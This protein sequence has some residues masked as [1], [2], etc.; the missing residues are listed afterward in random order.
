MLRR[1]RTVRVYAPIGTAAAPI[2][3]F[4]GFAARSCNDA[5][6]AGFDDGV[7]NT[8]RLVQNTRYGAMRCMETSWSPYVVLA[9]AN[10]SAGPPCRISAAS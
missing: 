7:T 1:P 4:V 3:S 9:P 5:I 2:T 8:S 6:P 10:T